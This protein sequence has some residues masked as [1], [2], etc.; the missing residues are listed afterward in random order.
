MV[1]AGGEQ[2]GS[3]RADPLYDLVQLGAHAIA[4]VLARCLLMSQLV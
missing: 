2:L 4:C 1:G 3:I